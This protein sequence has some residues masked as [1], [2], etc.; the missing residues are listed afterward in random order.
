MRT[1][2]DVDRI[3]SGY[4]GYVEKPVNIT[5][6]GAELGAQGE[7]WCAS[8]ASAVLE[9]AGFGHEFWSASAQEL[10]DQF[11]ERKLAGTKARPWSIVGYHMSGEHAGINHTGFVTAVYAWGLRTIEGNTSSGIAGSQVNGG[12]VYRRTRSY[13]NVVGYGYPPYAAA[14]APLPVGYWVSARTKKVGNLS[15]VVTLAH[16][17][18]DK[19]VTDARPGGSRVFLAYCGRLAALRI[20][21]YALSKGIVCKVQSTT[22]AHDDATMQRVL[23]TE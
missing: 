16:T 1:V 6:F 20:R 9:Q 5:K 3:A 4:V 10:H 7:P 23:A 8:F 15:L 13:L 19:A 11:A 12:G 17:L 21:A 22:M 18:G 14:P 2:A